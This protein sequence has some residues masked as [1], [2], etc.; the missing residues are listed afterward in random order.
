MA[1]VVSSIT[2]RPWGPSSVQAPAGAAS[3]AAIIQGEKNATVRFMVADSWFAFRSTEAVR[4]YQAAAGLTMA[5]FL[6][7]A[8]SSRF[9]TR[10]AARSSSAKVSLITTPGS[11]RP[12]LRRARASEPRVPGAPAVS[13]E[14][15]GENT[16]GN[17]RGSTRSYRSLH[18]NR[19]PRLP[20]KGTSPNEP[21][22][23]PTLRNP[24][25]LA[26]LLGTCASAAWRPVH[27]RGWHLLRDTGKE[28]RIA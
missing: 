5:S 19:P 9:R 25:P 13:P 4:S 7:P 26:A 20:D 10:A 22:H 24:V 28:R 3:V 21:E 11:N 17:H 8:L 6:A 16:G 23:T 2:Q 14:N 27:H 18:R 12:L 15:A 1:P